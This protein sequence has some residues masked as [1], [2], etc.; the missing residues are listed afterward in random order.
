MC[1]VYNCLLGKIK[2]I[3]MRGPAQSIVRLVSVV[4]ALTSQ[5]MATGGELQGQQP[6][7]ADEEYITGGLTYNQEVWDRV[8]GNAGKGHGPA[9][10]FIVGSPA[11]CGEGDRFAFQRV[12]FVVGKVAYLS[13]NVIGDPYYG[14]IVPEVIAANLYMA[15]R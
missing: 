14:G 8:S 13:L 11:V 1:L 2:H 12:P 3:K 6:R 15:D 7:L 10:I 4:S 5:Q 9:T